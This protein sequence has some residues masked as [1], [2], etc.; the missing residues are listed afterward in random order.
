MMK[1]MKQRSWILISLLLA[2]CLS[3]GGCIGPQEQTEGTGTDFR[4]QQS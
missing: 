4:T 3:L 1:M 2:I